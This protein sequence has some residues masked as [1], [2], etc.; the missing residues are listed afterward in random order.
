MN[1]SVSRSVA[2]SILAELR[3]AARGLARAPGFSAAGLLLLGVGL[4]VAV[5]MF[6]VLK[7]VVLDALPYPDADRVVVVDA[8]NAQLGASGGISTGEAQTFAAGL[9]TL[10]AFG[11]YSWSGTT[12]TPADGRPREVTVLGVSPQFFAAV[13][14]PALR[15]RT[16]D[17]ADQDE[18][19]SVAV[20]SHAEWMRQFAGAEDVVGRRIATAYGEVEVVG[21]MPREFDFPSSD[22]GMWLP[23]P[24]RAAI[25]PASPLWIEGRFLSAIA[26]L[27]PGVDV[28]QAEA[29]LA[30]A[31]RALFASRGLPEPQWR[32]RLVPALD[33]LLGDARWVLWGCFAIALLVLAIA[34]INVGLLMHARVSQRRR[35]HALAQALGASRGRVLRAVVLELSI[36]AVAGAM[37]GMCAAHFGLR[38]LGSGLAGALPRGDALDLDAGVAGA[39]L[40]LTA[41]AVLLAALLGARVQGQPG[42]ALRGGLR[43]LAVRTR[44][45]RLGPVLGVAMS[46]V[47]LVAAGA[48]GSS[49]YSLHAVDPGFRH[50]DV[51]A[52]Q[53]FRDGDLAQWRGFADEVLDALRAQPGIT[54]AAVT[55]AAPLSVI[56]SWDV[57]LQ[58]PDKTAV[59]AY[60]ATLRRVSPGYLR[61]LDVPLLRG[62]D[63]DARDREGSELVV[64]INETLA[65]AS[66]PGVDP[67]GRRIGLPIGTGPRMQFTVVGVMAD[68]RNRGPRRETQAEILVPFAQS[69]W[70]GMTFV[71]RSTLPPAQALE[72]IDRAI[73][74][75]APDEASTRRFSLSDELADTTRSTALF[76]RLLAAFALC[77]LL[78]ASFGVYALTSFQ[79][80]QRTAEFGLRLALGAR[81]AALSRT[82]LGGALRVALWGVAVGGLAAWAALGLLRSQLFGIGDQP[83]AVYAAAI[84]TMA[85]A[86]LLAGWLPARRARRVDPATTLRDA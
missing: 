53:L 78:L 38:A 8:V 42:D 41:I 10:A 83:A 47:A 39:G 67:L 18:E 70:Q 75:V 85:G 4:A 46:T 65:R 60:Q 64:V 81:P 43:L 59:E 58:L 14:T 22:V 20:L 1:E 36:L 11:Y 27:A 3:A 37:A 21:V 45:T 66:F 79:Q 30:Q 24:A 16:L 72:S 28:S 76:G 9:R 17:A 74:A 48:V 13:G 57:E 44:G 23:L 52:V 29:D 84:A 34:C 6:G 63:L 51:H 32:P 62:R 5:S 86:T 33:D 73:W 15:G 2:V 77:A 56:G 25:D 26:R 71:A 69:P 54:E 12:L 61:T 80:R 82:V 55:T 68:I 31:S 50:R 7:A 40:L 35:E 19:R 49:L